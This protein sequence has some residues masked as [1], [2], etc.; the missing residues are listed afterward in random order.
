PLI[1]VFVHWTY[2]THTV[3][4]VVGKDNPLLLAS[5]FSGTWPGLVALLN[6]G[7][8]LDS[9]NRPYSRVWTDSKDWSEDRT[10]MDRLDAW[11]STGQI[12]YP[13][14]ELHLTAAVND[15]AR[16]RAEAVAAE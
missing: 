7:A 6:T 2:A 12:R 10:F 11:C 1:G 15:A 3:D 14:N 8:S 9:L 4:G 16:Q 13:E 5:N